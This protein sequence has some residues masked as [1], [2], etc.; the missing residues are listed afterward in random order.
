MTST[1][2]WSARAFTPCTLPSSTAARGPMP[3]RQCIVIEKVARSRQLVYSA[4]GRAERGE[5]DLTFSSSAAKVFA[6]D[7]SMS[8]TTDAVQLFGGAGYT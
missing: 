5:P 7:A 2:R 3:S 6:S 1:V 8:V 4:A